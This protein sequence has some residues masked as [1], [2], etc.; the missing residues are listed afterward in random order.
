MSPVA[1]RAGRRLLA[2][3]AVA[4]AL[5]A[6]CAAARAAGTPLDAYLEGLKTWRANF[7]QTLNDAHGR[8]IERASGTLVVARPGRF[9]W[10]IH[11]QVGEGGGGAGTDAART[12]ATE[13]R[14]AAGQLMV[15]DGVN[16]WYLDR[17]LEQVTVKP[18]DEALSATPAMLLSGGGDVRASFNITPAGERS[19]L[20]WVLVEPRAAAADFRSALLGFAR[21]ELKRMILE[22]QLGQTAAVSF[23]HVQRNGPVASGEVSFSPPA[24]ADVI[25]TPRK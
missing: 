3:T 17:D 7:Q 12:H 6:L 16:L 13:H 18:V 4:L 24:G 2:H 20:D 15:C 1:R 23:E 21:G 22:D 19:G 8:Q 10:E 5:L 14:S 9:R 25:G 11:P